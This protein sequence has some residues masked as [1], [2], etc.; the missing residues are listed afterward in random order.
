[1]QDH[2]IRVYQTAEHPC[3]YFKDR[4]AR[5]LVLDPHDSA[6]SDVYAGALAM[7]FRRSGGHVYRP[8]CPQCS[9]CQA[10]RIDCRRFAPNRALRRNLRRNADVQLEVVPFSV[11]E[12]SFDLYRRY[13][14]HRHA[15]GGMDQG[16]LFDF[17]GFTRCAWSPT[18]AFRF[19][20]EDRLI[21][22]AVTDRVDDGISAVYTFYDPLLDKRGLGTHAILRQATWAAAQGVRFLYL[23]FWIKGHPKMDY[24]SRFPATESLSNGRWT[25]LTDAP[26]DPID[27]PGAAQA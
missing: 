7:G 22:M 11:D 8:R 20:L 27:P 19:T 25:P 24:K 9:A 12:A 5:D 1:M 2:R 15:G 21:A 3:G 18:L 4:V 6:L 14:G 13:V 26:R 23:G 10:V 16:D 17:A